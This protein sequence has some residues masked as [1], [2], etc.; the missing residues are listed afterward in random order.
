M[1]ALSLDVSGAAA[2][3]DWLWPA[4]A[5]RDSV[6]VEGYLRRIG[7]EVNRAPS[8]EVLAALAAHHATAIP[9]ENLNP[10][11]RLPVRLDPAS[12]QAKL[13][14]GGR[15]GYCFEHNL[16]FAHVLRALGYRVQGL[17][18]RVLWNAP[19]GARPARG[20]MLLRVELDE[21]Y[22]VDVGFGG[23]TL[24]GALRLIPEIEQP[25]PHE[26]FRLV[27]SAGEYTMEANIRGVWKPLYR[28]GLQPQELA[29]Y[30]LTSWYL[31][32][33]PDS[34]FLHGL[35]AA[36]AE[37]GRRYA[38]RN[39]ELSIHH[40]GGRTERQPLRSAGALRAV[41]EDVFR[42]SLPDVP[43]LGPALERIV[44]QAAGA[45]GEEETG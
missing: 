29:D 14:Y 12:L 19:E 4:G 10:L 1:S 9:F 2:T 27:P 43:A 20:H 41:L 21:P 45:T 30:A 18:A 16:L 24:T 6:D 39:A 36:R 28:F 37:P 3:A 25:T 32:H 33:H 38:L 34:H 5:A 35:I 31:T 23:L 13:V 26:P 42:I 11:L 22:V 40:A 17:A 8:A 7:C 15:G 44:R